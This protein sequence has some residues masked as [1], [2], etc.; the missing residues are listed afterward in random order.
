[1][2]SL[3]FVGGRLSFEGKDAETSNPSSVVVMRE[4]DQNVFVGWHPRQ[5][6]YY[7]STRTLRNKVNFSN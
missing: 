2:G 6:V 1:M 7:L 4:R 5:S 3:G